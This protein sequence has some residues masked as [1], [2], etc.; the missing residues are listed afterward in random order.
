[1]INDTE[2]ALTQ[3]TLQIYRNNA[4]AAAKSSP[5]LRA[6]SVVA[7][8]AQLAFH[9]LQTNK[10]LKETLH[11]NYAAVYDAIHPLFAKDQLNNPSWVNAQSDL[12]MFN[13][14][15]TKQAILETLDDH[16]AGPLAQTLLKREGRLDWLNADI[17]SPSLRLYVRNEVDLIHNDA[18]TMP[19]ISLEPTRLEKLERQTL[20]L[21]NGLYNLEA[22]ATGKSRN[23]LDDQSAETLR[24]E[25]QAARFFQQDDPFHIIHLRDARRREQAPDVDPLQHLII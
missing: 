14:V 16:Q 13:L 21:I 4:E 23:T 15:V 12:G 17:A 5:N 25:Q 1:M 8:D 3:R 19:G 7:W 2:N 10:A 6:F 20:K 22:W 11:G 18:D 9:V 24:Y